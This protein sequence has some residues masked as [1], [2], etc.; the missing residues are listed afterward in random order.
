MA[1]FIPEWVK[2]SGPHL[3]LKRLLTPLD[4]DHLVRR[5]MRSDLRA[6][7]LFLQR[8]EG[9]WLALALCHDP[10]A[11]I[12][13]LRLFAGDGQARL[14]QRL[15][16]LDRLDGV[17]APL[18]RAVGKLLVLWSCSPDEAARLARHHDGRFAVRIVARDELAGLDWAA[19]L[20]RPAAAADPEQVTAALLGRYFPE[21][22]IPAPCIA[23]RSFYRDN[24]AGLERYF[25][26]GDQEWTAKLDLETPAEQGQTAADL[27]VRLVNGV[28]GSGKTVIAISRARML[29]ERFPSDRVLLL[30]HNTPVVADLRQKLARALGRLPPRLEIVTFFAWALGRWRAR[31]GADP[32]PVHRSEV[33]A[34]IARKRGR[35]PGLR[36][37]DGQLLDE[38]DFINESLIAGEPEYLTARRA[39]RGFALRPAERAAV[40]ALYQHVTQDLRAS[41]QRLWSAIPHELALAPGGAE[42]LER[43]RHILVDEAQF[44]APSWFQVVKQAMR[45][46]GHLFMCADP[47]QGFLKSRLSWKSAGLEVA[48]RTKK[49]RRSYRTTRAI[50]EASS[51]I[52]GHLAAADAEDYLRPDLAAMEPGEPP[53]VIY[54]ASPQ[55]SVERASNEVMMLAQRRQLPLGGMLLVYGDG[56]PKE[57]LYRQLTQRL[58][59][60]AVWWLNHPQQKKGPPPG[61]ADDHLRLAHVSTATGLEGAV[62]FLLGVENLFS[63]EAPSDPP[64]EAAAAQHEANARKLYMAMTRAAQRLILLSCRPL[65]PAMERWFTVCDAP[66]AT[67]LPP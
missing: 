13:P 40:W 32:A 29:A 55:D 12:D 22:E 11:E 30:I 3:H 49:L 66:P 59:P 1:R 56:I 54:T 64:T 27:S 36:P 44:F 58:A 33:I 25:L 10:F 43:F 8:S 17:P 48:G 53:L 35:W 16:D 7:D 4:D 26:D 52:L 23:R 2:V 6:P 28:A 20:A 57:D 63:R 51:S 62:V 47:N 15:A 50:L 37:D 14:Q 67:P 41:G 60:P 9:G 61:G 24:R 34:Q 31:F 18:S 42:G 19:L 21:A 5:P 65:P 46:G 38:L 45:P 39:G